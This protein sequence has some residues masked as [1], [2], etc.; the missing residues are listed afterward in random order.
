MMI[1]A[2][3][4]CEVDK[5]LEAPLGKKQFVYR[6][7]LSKRMT[8][9]LNLIRVMKAKELLSGEGKILMHTKKIG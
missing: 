9:L 2:K 7:T 4:L 3:M 5:I 6:I 8:A 1:E